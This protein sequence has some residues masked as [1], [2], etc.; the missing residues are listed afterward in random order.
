MN[1]PVHD[2]TGR[3]YVSETHHSSGGAVAIGMS[4]ASG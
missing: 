4:R 2:E 1:M 3:R